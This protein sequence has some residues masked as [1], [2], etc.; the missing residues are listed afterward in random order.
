MKCVVAA[1]LAMCAVNAAQASPLTLV[2]GHTEAMV[3]GVSTP[4]PFSAAEVADA[5][6]G[7]LATGLSYTSLPDPL[8]SLIFGFNQT[9]EFDVSG[10][11]NIQSITFT[12]T[13]RY[14]WTGSLFFSELQL[15]PQEGL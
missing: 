4:V 3:G 6:D 1:L 10:L 9:F 15:A 13:G 14:T 2:S 12:W 8:S 11:S 7:S 5:S